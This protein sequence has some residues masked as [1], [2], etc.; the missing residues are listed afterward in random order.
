MKSLVSFI[1]GVAL[2]AV[3][4][5]G[6]MHFL[7]NR[8][9]AGEET[10]AAEQTAA[11][12]SVK[13][14]AAKADAAPASETK[15]S[16]AKVETQKTADLPKEA[17]TDE[18]LVPEA[19]RNFVVPFK[20]A[21]K[22]GLVYTPVFFPRGAEGLEIS[23][24]VKI[25][26]VVKG[27]QNWFDARIMMDFIDKANK[28]VNGGPAIGGWK[29]TKDWFPV[30]K[31]VKVANGAAGIALMPCLFNV[32]SGAMEVRNLSVVARETF[33]EDPEDR[34]RREAQERRNAANMLKARA[35]A[36]KTLEKYGSLIPPP[37]DAGSPYC[38]L[39]S[40]VP[41]KIVNSYKEYPIPEGVEAL[42]LSWNWKVEKLKTGEKPWFDARMLLKFKGADGKEIKPEPRPTYTQ[43]NTDGFQARAM[44]FLVPSNA[45]SLV[46]MPSLFQVKAGEM[47]ITDMKLVP[48]AASP[49]V[50]KAAEEAIHGVSPSTLIFYNAPGRFPERDVAEIARAFAGPHRP[51]VRWWGS[52]YGNDFPIE[53]AHLL[54]SAQWARENLGD[55]ME[56][57]YEADPCP[58][59]RFY[60]SAARMHALLSSVYA[61]GFSGSTFHGV[62]G[63]KDA[64]E[65][66]PD[67]LL[68]HKRDLARFE[69]VR[70]EAAKGRIVGVCTAFDPDMRL[71]ASC[72]DAKHPFD[73]RAWYHVLN[74]LGIPVTTAKASVTLYAGHHAFRHLSDAA[75]TNLLSGGVVLDGAAAEALT[76]RGFAPL[77]GAKAM[78]RDKIDFTKERTT[79][80][81]GSVEMIGSSF[82]QNYGLDGN[83]VSRIETQG[84]EN[85]AEFFS[86]SK[87]QPSITYFEN[88]L[89]GKVAVMAVNLADCKSPNIFRFQKR[90]LFVRLFRRIGGER[91]VPAWILDR[92]NVM[93]LANEG[94]G[95]LFLHAV[96]LS[97]D[98]TD[99]FELEVVPPYAG[100]KVEILEGAAWREADATWNGSNVTIRSYAPINVYGTLVLRIKK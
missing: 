60:A 61:M 59:S 5:V 10:V 89:G 20:G 88:A 53:T 8:K 46:V 85:V 31:T 82:H 69:A 35:S 24:E 39:V 84:A 23:C 65:K 49:L 17:I 72:A 95:R 50:A 83:A 9:G 43:R 37:K 97:C 34:A 36:M 81:D 7:S 18:N 11:E 86:A 74:L 45:I 13:P 100:G 70:R 1:A 38:S 6:V 67:Y 4:A 40:T 2:T 3:A 56:C 91:A 32:K 26:D 30:K 68:M 41:G 76:A 12:Q 63:G 94:S 14:E 21:G 42:R 92:G 47:T 99:S 54:Y 29:G 51:I 25:T 80:P 52:R 33:V 16:E 48:T 57:L 73:L 71:S 96:N 62:G 55:D 28:K 78:M 64:L 19:K 90:D 75:I 22:M 77:M 79:L 93:L 98:P 44:E 27:A 87:S 66:T 15:P 58:H